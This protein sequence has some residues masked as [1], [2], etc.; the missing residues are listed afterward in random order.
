MHSKSSSGSGTPEGASSSKVSAPGGLTILLFSQEGVVVSVQGSA[1]SYDHLSLPGRSPE[2]IFPSDIAAAFRNALKGNSAGKTVEFS[3]TLQEKKQ[4]MQFRVSCSPVY[5]DGVFN[6]SLA[7]TEQEKTSENKHFFLSM[8][9]EHYRTLVNLATVSIMVI[10]DG[11]FVFANP[12]T[13][14]ISGYSQEELIGRDFITL[15]SPSE[16]KRIGQFYTSR[17]LGGET[18]PVVYETQA[19]KRDGTPIDIE[20]TARQ[21]EYRGKP[22]IQV[23]VQDISLSKHVERELL[24]VQETLREKVAERTAELENYREHLQDIVDEKTT[25]LRNTVS[26]LR[27]EIKERIVAEERAEHLKQ[28]LKAI[29]SINLLITKET[30]IQVLIGNVCSR[31]VEARGYKDVWIMLKGEDGSFMTASATH[32]CE[33]IEPLKKE[34]IQGRQPPCIAKTLSSGKTWL[35]G[36]ADSVCS[37]CSLKPVSTEPRHIMS[38]RLEYRD[39]VFGVLT[40]AGLGPVVPD[41]EELGLFEE[42]C[43]DIAFALD[44]IEREKEKDLAHKALNES[45]DRYKALFENSGMAILFMREDMILD[46]NAKAAEI[47]RCRR[48]DLTGMRPYNLSPRMQPDGI[49]SAEKGAEK[50]QAAITEGSQHF[51]WIHTRTDGENF[52]AEISLNAVNIGGKNY[53][54]ALVN[55][56]TSRTEAEEALRLSE[57]NF[58]TLSN[59]VPVGIFRSDPSENGTLLAL[60]TTLVTMF[61]YDSEDDLLQG[62]SKKLFVSQQSRT[63]FLNR[64]NSSGVVENY[65]TP[66]R[67][68]DGTQFWASIS[69][70]FFIQND[71]HQ[72]NLIDGI[73]SDITEI[74]LQEETLRETLESFRKTIEGTVSAMSLLVEMKDPYTSG[75]Q[76]GVALLACAIGEEM[77]LDDD[78]I[79]CLRIASTLHDLGKLNVPL[80]ILNKP[81]PLNEFEM[82]FLRTHPGAGYDILKTVEFPWP[83]AEVIRQHHERQDGSGYPRGLKGD[84]ITIEASI[85]AVADVVE[86]VASRRPYRASMGIEAAL[87]IVLDGRGTFF[88]ESVVDSCLRLFREKGFTLIDHDKRVVQ[89]QFEF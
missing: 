76:K 52:P 49:S 69:A 15:I 42:V 47:F 80:E 21:L 3:Y 41:K 78:T 4:T 74:K 67:K 51:A 70:R 63:S 29:R 65:E 66:M 30:D 11:K 36:P 64:L 28:M 22:S 72:A 34:L 26:L 43:D 53:I 5:R 39:T 38:C 18:V 81:G 54:Q 62:S 61:G 20:V 46:C 35:S 85:I 45:E 14:D 24:N 48:K 77:G 16:R 87:D 13:S 89:T 8:E 31:L 68:K 58:R 73:I 7:V 71:K 27:I 88:K 1:K 6:G 10:A 12:V 17:L 44:S 32:N 75:H 19:L 55:D 59:N 37:D 57:N 9:E 79:D 33:D 86:A 23:I 60:N 25:R 2:D 84:E 50:I 83:I 82:D 40:V 56:I